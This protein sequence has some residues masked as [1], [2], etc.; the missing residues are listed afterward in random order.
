MGI[1]I[2]CLVGVYLLSLAGTYF[3]LSRQEPHDVSW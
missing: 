2:G 1:V 3:L